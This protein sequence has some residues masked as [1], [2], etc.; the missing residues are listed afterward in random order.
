LKSKRLDVVTISGEPFERG[1]EYGSKLSSRIDEFIE[2]LIDE[3][4]EPDIGKENILNHSGKYLPFIDDYSEDIY[5]EM[6]GIAE[7][8]GHDIEEIVMISLHEER[9]SFSELERNCTSFA[10][11]GQ[12]T[13][14]GTTFMGQTWDITPELCSNAKP[15]LLRVNRED[16]PGFLSYTYPG[17][18]AGA[19]LNDEGIGI[20][21]NSVPRLDLD[22]GVPTYVIIENVLRQK[23]IGKA[24]S[25][26]L[27]AKRAGCFNFVIADGTEIYTIEAT[28]GDAEIMYSRKT[29]GHANHYI[30]EKFRYSQ[31]ITQ[32]GGRCDSSTI[33]RYNRI[34][35]LLKEN[36][37]NI[38]VELLQK[39]TKDHVNFPQSICRHP[40]PVK[41][42]EQ[43]YVSCA[44]WVMDTTNK[45]WW[46]ANGP[47]CENE[48]IEYFAAHS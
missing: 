34:N 29:L 8:S 39:I 5:Q 43:G 42:D 7:G 24:L 14:G 4:S 28:P 41:E 20:S 9:S 45:K 47:A 16:G 22:F 37:G 3:F 6:K 25:T 31:D 40:E 12:A 32:A 2:Y 35:R 1:K 21:W 36:D 23:S 30:S 17:M 46:I 44:T 15:F 38:D 27:Q 13:K 19:G 10:A 11:T 18:L 33:I 48:F 26:V